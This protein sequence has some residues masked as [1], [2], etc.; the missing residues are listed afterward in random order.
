MNLT[1]ERV[2]YVQDRIQHSYVEKDNTV[3]YNGYSRNEVF[4]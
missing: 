3:E 2:Q 1:I 4:I